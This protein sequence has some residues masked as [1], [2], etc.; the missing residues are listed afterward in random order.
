MSAIDFLL[1]AVGMYLAGVAVFVLV[2]ALVLR[3][4]FNRPIK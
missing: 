4:F 1:Y 2:G 3:A